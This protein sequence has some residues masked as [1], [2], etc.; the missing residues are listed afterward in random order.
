LSLCWNKIIY[1]VRV[2]KGGEEWEAG[3]VPDYISPWL[4]DKVLIMFEVLIK[5]LPGLSVHKV[6]SILK[7]R[8][9]NDLGI[10]IY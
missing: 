10:F 7:L 8:L 4:I 5:F 2:N 1:I 3:W 6:K 9:I